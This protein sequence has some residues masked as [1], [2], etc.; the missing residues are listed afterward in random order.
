MN[1]P[2]PKKVFTL[3]KRWRS[4]IAFL[5]V[6]TLLSPAGVLT[7]TSNSVW[8]ANPLAPPSLKTAVVPEPP[9]LAN[10]VRNKTAAIQLG[11]ALFWD[12]QLGSD[13]VQAC[14]SCHFHAG[15]DNRKKNQLSPGLLAGDQTFDKG[16]P[17]YTLKA[18]DFPFHQRQA[19]KDRQSSPVIANTNED[20]KSVV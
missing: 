7:T 9:D 2:K 6:L 20:R 12:M 15:A 10:Y 18:Q 8:A 1:H 13:G 5:L 16:G 4:R 11:K 3:P 19:P 17:N 14:A